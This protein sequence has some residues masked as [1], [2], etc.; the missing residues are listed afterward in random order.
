MPADPQQRRT[1]GE[2]FAN[3][4]DAAWLNER[5]V[6]PWERGQALLIGGRTFTPADISQITVTETTQPSSALMP[7]LS[8]TPGVPVPEGL[9]V[10]HLGADV[11]DQFI[12][13]PS[14]T[15]LRQHADPAAD[16]AV[17]SKNVMVIYGHD[18]EANDALFD[19]LRRIE[20]RPLEFNELVQA[21]GTASPYT[22]DAVINAFNVAQAVIAFFTPDEYVLDRT[23]PPGNQNSWRIQARPNVLIEAGMALIT[24]PARTVIG[25]LGSGELPSDLAGRNYVRLNHTDARPLQDLATRLRDVAHCDVRLTGT[26][27]LNPG[28]FPDRYNLP[29]RPPTDPA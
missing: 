9:R 11:T 13:G 14:G 1:L 16:P 18:T 19:W 24:H 5:V 4:K 8:R 28:R 22:G 23:A 7:G 27:W 26:D 12:T 6:L 17:D 25:I 29:S 15:R 20:L 21:T 2:A 10:A 3:D